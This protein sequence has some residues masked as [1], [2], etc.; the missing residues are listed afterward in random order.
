MFSPMLAAPNPAVDATCLCSLFSITNS[1][2]S[3]NSS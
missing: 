1:Y 2:E 3:P